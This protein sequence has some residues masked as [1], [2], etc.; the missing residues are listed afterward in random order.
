M[1]NHQMAPMIA[2]QRGIQVKETFSKA[3]PE[4]SCLLSIRARMPG[5]D[6]TICGAVNGSEIKIIHIDG[7]KVDI[8]PTGN[9]IIA[10]HTDQPG[11]I[12]QTGTL[13]GINKVNIAGMHVGRESV[14]G[15]A[16]MVL[17]ID[18][19]ISD[20]LMGKIRAISGMETAQ[21]VTL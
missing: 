13:L 14:G 8:D 21:F 15:R 17:L 16:T 2:E 6:R 10:Q 9:M 1:T 11:M 12:G 4:H 18:E 7:Y 5:G 3:S 20:E 19:P